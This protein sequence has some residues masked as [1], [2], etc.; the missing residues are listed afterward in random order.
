MTTDNI[1]AGG[2]DAPGGMMLATPG[3]SPVQFARCFAAGLALWFV[4][5]MLIRALEPM[6]ALSPDNAMLTYALAVPGTV[7]VV[8]LV[9]WLG[10][11]AASQR[12]MGMAIGTAAATMAD[13][14]A[15]VWLPQLYGA[16]IAAAGAVILWGAG[17]GMM[18]GFLFNRR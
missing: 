12:A 4:A 2:A 13:G 1:G 7:P 16:N 6:G 11:L 14:C 3:L 5:A 9:Q 8:F 18:L 10:G 17:V 15:L